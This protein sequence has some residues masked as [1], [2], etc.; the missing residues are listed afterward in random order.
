LSV[1]ERSSKLWNAGRKAASDGNIEEACRLFAIAESIVV[2]ESGTSEETL[3][4]CTT[5]GAAAEAYLDCSCGDY[6][7]AAAR[8][9]GSY[10]AAEV[11]DVRFGYDMMRAQQIH[12]LNNASRVE[13]LAGCYAVAVGLCGQ[14]L[15]YLTGRRPDVDLGSRWRLPSL[16]S[17]ELENA[18]KLFLASQTLH[19][20][21][22]ICGLMDPASQRT[23]LP[24]LNDWRVRAEVAQWE[25]LLVWFELKRRFLSCSDSSGFLKEA[26]EFFADER[27]HLSPLLWFTVAVDV[28][29]LCERVPGG[30]GFCGE[31]LNGPH[32]R[33][34]PH[35]VPK[36]RLYIASTP[37]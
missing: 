34:L 25:P 21:A 6:A 9:R 26:H 19:E 28:A 2:R 13:A 36:S 11:L 31:V 5:I 20:L 29:Y 23:A 12:L 33:Y 22:V 7:Q 17:S 15:M 14:V 37:N 8:L 30:A 4:L 24:I 1:F 3:L 27:G 16:P 10:D 32:A 35:L 18:N